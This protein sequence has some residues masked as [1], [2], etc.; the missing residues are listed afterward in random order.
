MKK[1]KTNEPSQSIGQKVADKVAATVGSWKFILIQSSILIFWIISN[2]TGL[3]FGLK[4]DEPPFILLNLCLSFQAAYTAPIIMMSQ[5]RQSQI[6]RRR[7]SEDYQINTM[8]E[9]EIELIQAQVK[10]IQ[11]RI[12][13]DTE[14][15]QMLKNIQAQLV[16]IKKKID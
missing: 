10:D 9:Q 3:F 2:S 8:A 11:A 6:D 1:I 7:A 15:K 16:S 12:G 4:W 13:Q 14:T 5:N